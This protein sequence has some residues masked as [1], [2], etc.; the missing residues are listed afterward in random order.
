M[1]RRVAEFAACALI[2]SSVLPAQIPSQTPPSS[3]LPTFRTSVDVVELDVTVLDKDRHPVKGLTAADFT[4]LERGKPQLIVAFNSIDVPAPARVPAPWMRDAPLDV[5]SNADNRRLVTIVMDDAYTRLEPMITQRAKQIAR[6]AVDQLGPSDLASVVFT[7]LGRAQNF[8][9]DRTQ[10]LA[11]IDSYTPK[12]I[13]GEPPAVCLPRHRSCDVET[14]ATVAS[15]MLTA[16][17]GRKVVILISGGRGFTFGEMGSASSRNETRELD[18]MFTNLQRANVTVYAFDAHGLEAGQGPNPSLY[19][20]AESTGGRAFVNTNDPASHVGGAFLESS[21]YYL[22]GFQSSDPGTD[23]R[24]R[25]IEVKV[26]RP[27]VEVRTR[28]GY[29]APKN[30]ASRPA[31]EVINGLPGGDLPVHVT[32]APFAVPGRREAEVIIMARLEPSSAT[33]NQTKVA[34]AATAIDTDSKSYGTQRQTMDVTSTPGSRT[35]PDLPSHLPLPPGRY[36]VRLAAE[37]EGR[38]GTVFV[39]VEVP[40]FTKSPLSLSGLVLQRGAAVRVADKVIAGLIPVAP[41]TVREFST[42]DEVTVFLRVY[43]GGKGRVVPVRM[44]AKVT[45]ERNNVTSNQDA[46]IEVAD[47]GDARSADYRVMLP[48]A[49]LAPGDYL[50]EVEAQSGARRHKRSARFTVVSE[51]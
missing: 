34:L 14:L 48:L 33:P 38:T 27:G 18:E 24:F 28:T 47:F 21:T 37:S 32:A 12:T 22:V 36:M 46:V 15:T 43:Q 9:A 7:F 4:V 19:S 49:H 13:G 23:G 30:A 50:L 6:N 35:Q 26:N 5:V 45:S 10:L 1:I 20:F 39:D 29:Y 16:P 25:K 17:P 31:G 51:R 11:G 44:L 40:E 8:T 2:A 41:T 42:A 3:Q